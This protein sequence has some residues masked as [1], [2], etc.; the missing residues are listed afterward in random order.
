MIYYQRSGAFRA[1]LPWL[2]GAVLLILGPCPGR[3]QSAAG[4]VG[5]LD[6]VDCN[7]IGGWA[8]NQAS[9]AMTLFIDLYE[10]EALI[11]TVAADRFRPDLLQNGIG[12]GYHA[13]LLP[14]PPAFRDGQRH[15]ITAKFAGTDIELQKSG[16]DVTCP[17]FADLDTVRLL[18]QATFGPSGA[19]V[20]HV[21][22][23]GIESFLD[24]QFSAPL[25]GYPSMPYYPTSAPTG[26]QYVSSDPY[27]PSSLCYRDNYSLFPLQLRFFR[28]ALTATD[29]L[30]Q[31]VAFALSQIF[32][33]SGVK[34]TQPYALSEFQ[35]ILFRNAFG[36]FR[37]LL[38]EVTLSPAMGRYLDMVNNDKPN[39]QRG[40]SANENYAREILQLFSVGLY[41]LN[42]DGS[43]V[44]DPAGKPVPTYTQSTIENLARVFTG[45]TYPTIP[46]AKLQMRNPTYFLGP[47]ELYPGNHDTDP[48]TLLNGEVL[49]AGQTGDRDLAD[50][51]DNIFRHANVGPF[52]G[53][54]LI[55]H[56]VTSNPS[57]DY[58]S[59]V[60]AVFGDNGKGVRGDL[61]AVVRAILLDPEARGDR[62]L[63]ADYGHL[64]EPV[65]FIT[66][67]MRALGGVS[68]GVFLKDQ[69]SAMGQNLFTSPTVFNF[70]PPDFPLPG[71]SL[72]GPEFALQGGPGYFARANFIQSLV[73]SNGIVP[74]PGV[75]PAIGTR[76]DLSP[77]I[78]L[79]GDPL[80]LVEALDPLLM[81]GTMPWT[82]RNILF[83]AISAVPLTDP[84][85]RVRTAV[86]L[87]AT[88]SAFQ[89]ER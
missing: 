88:S 17:A 1:L 32:V 31:R 15:I 2:L 9:P 57:P 20:E 47:M 5:F 79:T 70:Y 59:R 69:S 86:Y 56:L 21:K 4:R 48:K 64:K 89:V 33:I 38:Q 74:S 26:C 68:D 77:W 67:L 55:Q 52:I 28:N 87:I 29:Q 80:R 23:I 36:N 58:V 7:T 73:F 35:Q 75:E 85:T 72:L 14:I 83:N 6:E 66:H 10:G 16:H 11:D 62:R 22:K 46:G 25:S 71:S 43:R 27:G 42:P 81:H 37:Q 44:L 8:W 30:R 39:P 13:F 53:R 61:R 60:S 34:I 24:E 19:L 49:P 84:L 76:I 3:A 50:A 51:L 18:E 63:E 12:D 65:L 54:Q 82:M 40:I 45:W 41:L 78:P